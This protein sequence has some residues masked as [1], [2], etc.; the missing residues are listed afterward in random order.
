MNRRDF[1]HT[2]GAGLALS[3]LPAVH[4][5]QAGTKPVRV[6][7]V[8]TGWYGK[9]SLLRLIQVAPVE[10]VETSYS[11]YGYISMV[12]TLSLVCGVIFELPL[13]MCFLSLIGIID[14]TQLREWRRYWI[15]A[16]FIIGGILTPPDPF[17]QT[18]MAVPLLGLYEVG[19][20]LSALVSKP[21]PPPE[22]VVAQPPP[23]PA[24]E[25]RYREVPVE[26]TYVTQPDPPQAQAAESAAA[27]FR[28]SAAVRGR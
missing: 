11:V 26:Q 7:L 18:L 6:G 27:G 5:G 19:I 8:G 12:I 21:A 22:A 9:C 14:A 25:D 1:L 2:A 17:T 20:L 13:F 3:S 23:E 16:A 15:L 10:I 28:G 4:A 24:L